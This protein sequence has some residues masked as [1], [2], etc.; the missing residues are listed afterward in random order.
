MRPDGSVVV[1]ERAVAG[2]CRRHRPHAPARPELLAHEAVDDRVDAMLGDDPAPQEMADVRRERVDPVLLAVERERV[3]AAAVL[4]TRTPRRSGRA[5]RPPRARAG[6]RGRG[7]AKPRAPARPSAASR[8]RRSPAPRTAAIGPVAWRPSWKSW[9]LWESFHDWFSSPR[10]DRRWYSTNPS[11][12]RSPYSSIQFSARMAGSRSAAHE[13][14]VVRPAPHLGEEHEEERRRVDRAVVAREPG[15][16]RLPGA[17][18][19]DDLARLGVRERI[20]L[21][22]LQAGERRERVARQ[23]RP[24]DERLEARDQRVAAEHG[25]EP[26]HPGGEELAAARRSRACRSEARSATERSN[27]V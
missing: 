16:R 2:V 8:R 4:D 21:G 22:R 23:L 19:V 11:P 20:V 14:G 25:H 10:S 12:S 6:R 13:R 7:R 27:V 24:E 15:R 1:R 17:D 3:E 18:L 26:G 5:A 9:E